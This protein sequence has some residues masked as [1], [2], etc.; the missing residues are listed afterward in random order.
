MEDREAM[1]W[2]TI[3]EPLDLVPGR[4]IRLIN[5]F[6]GHMDEPLHCHIYHA[7]LDDQPE[8]EA[9]SYTWATQQGDSSQSHLI[10]CSYELLRVTANC[11]MALR[12]VRHPN[13]HRTIWIDSVCIDQANVKERNHQVSIMKHIYMQASRVLI[14]AGESF[15]GCDRVLKDLRDWDLC[16]KD[17][18]FH[19]QLGR[20][21]EQTIDALFSRA[22][23]QRI[24]V[25][26]EV[27][28]AKQATI[29]VGDTALDWSLFSLSRFCSLGFQFYMKDGALPCIMK[30]M[31]DKP[32][33]LLAALVTT[34]N[35]LATDPR[36]KV[37]A[38][39]SLLDDPLDRPM[40]ADYALTCKQVFVQTAAFLITRRNSLAVLSEVEEG[41]SP[42]T[43]PSWVPDWST[44]NVLRPLEPQFRDVEPWSPNGLWRYDNT[45]ATLTPSTYTE[46]IVSLTE[47]SILVCYATL[48]DTVHSLYSLL[49]DTTTMNAN[50][51]L[52]NEG[53]YTPSQYTTGRKTRKEKIWQRDPKIYQ[54]FQYHKIS[55]GAGRRILNTE[56]SISIVPLSTQPGDTIWRL[57][58][59]TVPFVLR[60]SG[61]YYTLV[62]ACYLHGA[63]RIG[64]R[65]RYGA[66]YL[67]HSEPVR[68]CG[69]TRLIKLR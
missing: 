56:Q 2:T 4:W 62:G 34:R 13:C 36:D 23:F 43:L 35:C 9:L 69:I 12:R 61:G 19:F 21:R 3:H 7:N 39:Q 53:I 32:C 26:Q 59:A 37:F 15:N 14:Y 33:N 66:C 28:L 1:E 30:W 58:G 63:E 49:P 68:N 65:T 8:Y 60:D 5:L 57:Q 47:A 17:R 25:L 29:I 45:N 40:E 50:S 52:K 27:M 55:K 64:C 54:V 6:A 41:R 44:R 51:L 16:L 46:G 42:G 24:W 11:H 18:H 38:L 31:S 48:L 20:N 67:H 22:W 10:I